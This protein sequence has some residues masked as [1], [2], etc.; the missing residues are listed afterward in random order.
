MATWRAQR[1]QD[2]V[3]SGTPWLAFKEDVGR[4]YLI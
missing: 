1:A 2:G 3:V 4:K